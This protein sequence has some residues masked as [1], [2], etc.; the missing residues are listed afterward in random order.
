[1]SNKIV[2]TI[3]GRLA[4]PLRALPYMTAWAEAPDSLVSALVTEPTLRVGGTIQQWAGRRVDILNKQ[5]LSAYR[6]MATGRWK[7][8]TA[9]QWQ[10]VA[11]ELSCLTK[12]LQAD[13]RPGAES[14]NHARWRIAATLLLPDDV[15]VWLDDFERWFSHTRPL[16]V[17]S[18]DDLDLWRIEQ[19]KLYT[20]ED[21]ALV[22]HEGMCDFSRPGKIDF[23][24]VFPVE[25]MGRIWQFGVGESGQ[26]KDP[27]PN[28]KSRLG[29]PPSADKK[30]AAVGAIMTRFVAVGAFKGDPM[31]LPGR[32]ANL[33]DACKRIEKS[34]SGK[35]K[36]FLIKEDSFRTW[37]T[38]AGY[39]FAEGRTLKDEET[40]W[41]RW[42]PEIV[43]KNPP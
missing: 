5:A 12:Q 7:A 22:L 3:D 38:K 26:E 18:D 43:G 37:L 15:F 16:A 35:T 13:E 40:Y 29:R 33:L 32:L 41:T 6:M 39:G 42:A 11:V 24:V 8:I 10:S 17:P 34:E 9:S 4:L 36:M 23:D 25:L 28:V 31:K 19:A 2:V 21:L 30:A 20:G 1:M 27:S 14:E